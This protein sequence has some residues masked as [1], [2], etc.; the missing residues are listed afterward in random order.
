MRKPDPVSYTHLDGYKRQAFSDMGWECPAI[1][2]ALESVDGLYFDGISQ[3]RM[4][5][6]AKGRVALVGDAAACP[7]LCLLYTSRCV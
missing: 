1:L 7:S 5:E 2:S 4:D 3:I 6:W